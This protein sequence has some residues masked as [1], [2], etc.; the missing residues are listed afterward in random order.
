MAPAAWAWLLW[1]VF[2][3]VG[4]AVMMPVM[5]SPPQHAALGAALGEEGQH[6][7]ER[8]AGLVGAMREVAVVGAGHG[9]YADEIE[10]RASDG[11]RRGN[12]GPDR[13]EGEHVDEDEWGCP[14]PANTTLA[15][16]AGFRN[17]S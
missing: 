7:L 4:P 12:P 13:A 5:R 11:R 3:L 8:A 17:L 6:E 16:C 9:E 1:Q 10:H 14:Q 2:A 15:G